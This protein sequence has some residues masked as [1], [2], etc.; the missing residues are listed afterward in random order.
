MFINLNFR[1]NANLNCMSIIKIVNVNFILGFQKTQ[2]EP[3]CCNPVW[4]S[5]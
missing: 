4:S 3:V 1:E 5:S 2:V